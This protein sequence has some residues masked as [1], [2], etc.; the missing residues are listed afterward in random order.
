MDETG[1]RISNAIVKLKVAALDVTPVV[2]HTGQDGSFAFRAEP[3]R[4]YDLTIEM[5]GF[6]TTAKTIEVE[7]DEE[8]NAGDIVMPVGALSIVD[9][10]EYIDPTEFSARLTIHGIGGTSAT[11]SVADLSMM[12]QRTVKAKDHGTPVTFEGALLTDVLRKVD[13]PLGEK[14][15]GT[16]ASY[17]LT[18]EAR[19]SYEAVFAWAE[20]DSTFMNKSMYVVTK[21]NGKPLSEKD[22]PFQ[23]LVPGEKRSARWVRQLTALTIRQAD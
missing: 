22:G 2:V 6:Q 23:L 17:Y 14:F 4:K 21:R 5:A 11:L 12:P 20:L 3:L 9:R 18:A 19:D 8:F 10:L 16:C 7:T 1:A 13:L 15:H